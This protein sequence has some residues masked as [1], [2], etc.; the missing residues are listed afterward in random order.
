M[1]DKLLSRLVPPA[2]EELAGAGQICVGVWIYIYTCFAY[3]YTCMKYM[4]SLSRCLLLRQTRS[5]QAEYMYVYMNIYIHD[6]LIC[7]RVW[8]VWQACH[9]ARASSKRGARRS[10]ICVCICICMYMI[11]LFVYVYEMYE[12][13]VLRLIPPANEE[14]AGRTYV[15]VYTYMHMYVHDLHTCAYG[16]ATISR[17]LKIISLLCKI[18]GLFCRT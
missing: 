16:V 7:I 2:N 8:H 6:L 15:F 4:I 3:L 9:A 11:C 10:K 5:S 17:L 18:V 14:L 1:Y 13:L 12:K